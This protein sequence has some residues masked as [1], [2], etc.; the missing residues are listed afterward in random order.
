VAVKITAF[1]HQG[2]VRAGNED[3][4]AAGAWCRNKPMERPE[5]IILTENPALALV[6]DGMGGH[7]AGEVASRAVALH[8]VHRRAALTGP[9][10]LTRVVE[11]ANAELFAL[12]DEQP[13]TC[14]MGTTVAGLSLSDDEVFVFNVG[15][16]RVLGIHDRGL[17]QLSTDDTPGPKLADGRTAAMTSSMITQ[18]LGG[19]GLE[20]LDVH[21]LGDDVPARAG[22]LI[23]S[24]GL[25][26]LVPL[27]TM[28]ACLGEPDDERIVE[29]LFDA[30]MTAGGDDNVSILLVRRD[31]G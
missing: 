23:A 20:A 21:V 2:A 30:A 8:L 26:D 7:A 15:D 1:T 9:Q 11:E 27:A 6:C 16:S 22:W 14:G 28:E 18:V 5:R 24:D 3:T 10:M 31:G 4:I 12:M 19:Y 13:A 17:V 25:T 29:A